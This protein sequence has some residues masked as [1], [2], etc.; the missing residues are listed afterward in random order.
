MPAQVIEHLQ[1]AHQGGAA[2]VGRQ[3]TELVSQALKLGSGY[4]RW[5]SDRGDRGGSGRLRGTQGDHLC[6]R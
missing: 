5:G 1:D 6:N 3:E 4:G 2:F